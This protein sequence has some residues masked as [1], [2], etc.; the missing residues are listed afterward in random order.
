MRRS[1]WLL[2]LLAAVVVPAYAHIGNK[3][4]FEQISAGPYKLFLT[5]RPPRVIP[6]IATIEVRSTGAAISSLSVMPMP[7]GGEASKHPPAPDVL[8]VSK[9]D[10]AFYTGYLWLMNPGS[11]KVVVAIDG[12]AGHRTS[13]V[14]VSAV[15]TEI[16]HMQR[17]L[18]ILLGA[19]GLI[20]IIGLVCIVDA[21]VSEAQLG[22]GMQPGP[23]RRRRATVAS[24]V[25]LVI[26]GLMAY[27]YGKWWNVL[28]AQ[29]AA[30]IY[31]AS[32][33]HVTLTGNTL[34]LLIGN[35]DAKQPG[36]WVALNNADLLPDHGHLM[37]LYAIR[38][39]E[40]DSAF[41]L[42][43]EPVGKQGLRD[44]LPSMPPGTYK[45]FADIVFPDGF[46]ETETATL[47]VPV[48]MSTA[49]LASEDA[50]AAP[51]ALTVG[52]LGSSYKFPDGYRMV[53]D[54]PMNI[55]ANK[56]YSFRFTLLD[57]AGK[58][59][60]DMQPY[61]GMAGH[62]AFV[63]TDGSTFAHTHPEG[64]AAM[65]AMMLAN[66]D[67]NSQASGMESTG[68]MD[69]MPGMNMSPESSSPI[70]EFPYGFPA[71]GRYRIFVQMKHGSTVET[72]VF[73][74]AVH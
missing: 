36:K 30:Q 72:G 18:G 27:G 2:L 50:S 57:P 62:A 44:R 52:E 9:V 43:P 35:P 21:S 49:P 20:L 41:H 53:W 4:V 39:P 7:M 37:H 26:V 40:M 68:G 15:P 22:P 29:S 45:L 51:P 71:S 3:D 16:R 31:H 61:L 25:T 19:L 12:V 38:M 8:K 74:T 11:W 55:E 5:I 73:D 6:G 32:E 59:A 17:P 34:D 10:P 24:G 64:S 14:A 70:V 56:G 46:P 13:S 28:A 69:S 66:P 54:K 47:T 58:L 48:G 60:M 23:D 33:L 1:T 63:K 65:P 42:H 67:Q